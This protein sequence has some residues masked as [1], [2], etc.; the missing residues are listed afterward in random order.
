MQ[1][2]CSKWISWYL[3]S[4]NSIFPSSAVRICC[5]LKCDDSRATL[6]MSH[7]YCIVVEL[8]FKY[9]TLRQCYLQLWMPWQEFIV[10]KLSVN[11]LRRA[12]CHRFEPRHLPD[13]FISTVYLALCRYVLL[14]RLSVRCTGHWIMEKGRIKSL[15]QKRRNK[16]TNNIS[17]NKSN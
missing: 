5:V 4:G 16:I 15:F 17:L 1:V 7:T 12:E 9:K 13:I 3:A 14:F 11:S 2:C 10:N 6:L 8:S